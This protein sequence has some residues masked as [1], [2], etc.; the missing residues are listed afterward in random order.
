MT[1]S[2]SL[3]RLWPLAFWALLL[4]ITWLSLVPVDQLP[5]SFSFWDKAQHA[6]GFAALGL[7]GLLAYPQRPRTVLAALLLYG[8]AIE[9]AQAATGWRFGEWSDWLADGIGLLLG[10]LAWRATTWALQRLSRH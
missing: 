3:N 9:L 4:T 6:L 1:S 2:S 5:P 10:S 8:G 7:A